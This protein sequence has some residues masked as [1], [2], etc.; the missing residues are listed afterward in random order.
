MKKRTKKKAKK[1]SKT[2]RSKTTK[3][4]TGVQ[5]VKPAISDPHA[6]HHEGHSVVISGARDTQHRG[7]E[8]VVRT[9]Y[10]IT[11]DG[12]PFGG[13]VEL[14]HAGR[15]YTHACPYQDF[16]SALDMM[17]HIIEAYPDAFASTNGNCH[18][19]AHA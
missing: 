6:G 12:Q 18:Q 2:R 17:K 15:L 10:E 9:S 13:H 16:A 14:D 3:T 4:L 11:V 1:K 19:E 7:H 5:Q 8:I